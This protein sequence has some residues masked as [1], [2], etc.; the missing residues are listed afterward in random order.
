MKENHIFLKS[1]RRTT[2]IS[3]FSQY[4]LYDNNLKPY[5]LDHLNS[6]PIKKFTTN[7][8]SFTL[9]GGY[10]VSF[11]NLH[12]RILITYNLNSQRL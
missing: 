6:Y 4:L 3:E 5:R 1:L 7:V 8:I 9:K 11:V 10:Q 12:I 2:F